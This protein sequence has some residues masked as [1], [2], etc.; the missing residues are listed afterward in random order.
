MNEGRPSIADPETL[1]SDIQDW[2]LELGFQQLGVSDIDLERAGS[3][4]QEWLRAGFHGR[5]D[6]MAM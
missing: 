2:A 4:L 5:M 1:K 3:R 6:Y